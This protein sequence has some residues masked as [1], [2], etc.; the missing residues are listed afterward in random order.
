MGMALFSLLCLICVCIAPGVPMSGDA[1]RQSSASSLS[2]SPME[3][4]LRSRGP[5]PA[6][7][8]ATAARTSRPRLHSRAGG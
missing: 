1:A 6:S 3:V 7:G 5:S 8:A 2:K 4:L